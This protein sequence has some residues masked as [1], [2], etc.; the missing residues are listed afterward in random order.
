MHKLAW[1]PFRVF[2]SSY[3]PSNIPLLCIF[4]LLQLYFPFFRLLI[5]DMKPVFG[6]CKNV[7]CIFVNC[8]LIAIFQKFLTISG[9]TSGAHTLIWRCVTLFTRCA[10]N[11]A[12]RPTQGSPTR[13][14]S[15]SP[16]TESSGRGDGLDGASIEVEGNERILAAPRD[17]SDRGSGADD[18]VLCSRACHGA[19]TL[20]G[21]CIK[22]RLSI[23]SVFFVFGSVCVCAYIHACTC[24]IIIRPNMRCVP[25]GVIYY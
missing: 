12:G 3:F 25:R 20:I 19:G 17:D 7:H 8:L 18:R 2:F 21:P 16:L 23:F 11:D 5:N 24:S 14:A 10:D 9:Q 22:N 6:V 15:S 13:S 4:D 1:T